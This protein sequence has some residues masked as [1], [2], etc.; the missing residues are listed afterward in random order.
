MRNV[1][2]SLLFIVMILSLQTIAQEQW[3]TYTGVANLCK[4]R[5]LE[6]LADNKG[7]IWIT[8]TGLSKYSG[9]QWTYFS[10]DFIWPY[11]ICVAADKN[12]NTWVGT[13]QG[14]TLLDSVG[15]W[16]SY[17]IKNCGLANNWIES[18]AIDSSRV[19]WFGT[20][21]GVSSFNGTTWTNYKASDG[22]AADTVNTIVVDKNNNKWF[23]TERGLSKFDG[24][25][26]KTYTTTDGLPANNINGLSIDASG[27]IW[28]ATW[29]GLVK[30]DGS[31]WRTYT[32]ADGLASDSIWSVTSRGSIVWAGFFRNEQKKGAAKFDGTSWTNYTIYDETND[33]DYS[34]PAVPA[35]AIDTFGDAWFASQGDAVFVQTATGTSK[36]YITTTHMYPD[37]KHCAATDADGFY[38]WFGSDGGLTAIAEG[39][40]AMKYTT[41]GAPTVITDIA[42]DITG[43]KWF[44]TMSGLYYLPNTWDAWV[45]YKTTDGLPT[46]ALTTVA[47]D[48]ESNKWIG[49]ENNGVIFFNGLSWKNY[50]TADGLASNSITDIVM[51]AKGR[52]WVCTQAS[53]ISCFDGTTWKNYTTTDGLISDAVICAALDIDGSLWFGTDKGLSKFDGTTWTNY[54][55]TDGLAGNQ[56]NVIKIDK[57]GV[58][59]IGCYKHSFSGLT[60]FDNKTWKSFTKNNSVDEMTNVF[61]ITIDGNGS[62]WIGTQDGSIILLKDGGAT[63]YSSPKRRI[64]GTLF[65]DAN[66][67]GIKDAGESVLGLDKQIVKVDSFYTTTN[68][69]GVFTILADAGK[70]VFTYVPYEYW[71]MTTNQI[72]MTTGKAEEDSLYIGLKATQA[73][74]DVKISLTGSRTRVLGSSNYWIDFKNVGSVSQSGSIVLTLDSLVKVS[75]TSSIP[76]TITANRLVWNFK[77]LSA[78]AKGQILVVATMPDFTHLGDTLKT[79]ASIR[80]T[81]Q[82]M[83]LSNNKSSL[84]Q[85]LVGSYDP[86][87]KEVAQGVGT[88]NYVL[89]NSLLEYTIHFQNTGTDTAYVVNIADTINANLD[90]GTLQI[91]GSSHTV[92][93]QIKDARTVIFSFNKINLPPVTKNETASNGYIKYS[94]KPITGL[95]DNTE[96]TNSASIYFDYN[97]PILT[98]TTSNMFVSIIPN[99]STA[100]NLITTDN[101]TSVYPNPTSDGINIRTGLPTEV[102]LYSFT[103]QTL[104]KTT[105]TS[106]TYIPLTGFIQGVYFLKLTNAKGVVEQKL[107]KK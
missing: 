57:A 34:R 85:V 37:L 10:T 74:A 65:N 30:Y 79:T 84:C 44:S 58:K 93:S 103:G 15:T 97:S 72:T 17:T 25:T 41:P 7:T 11:T 49:T 100:N 64:I 19:K 66:G 62:K 86:N 33:L 26:W 105:I 89:H 71:Q 1:K 39:G 32:T 96:V 63:A 107:I 5:H 35:L 88:K 87:D 59:W 36:T 78:Q 18:V 60:K 2:L 23:G 9:G 22:L 83:D 76:D 102:T 81:N 4:D 28:I 43:G 24:S 80:I 38:N 40:N 95:A 98:D 77:D 55:T 13:Y 68:V 67:N 101:E 99:G 91:I 104:L 90:L 47:V 42:V 16:T 82:D 3:R 12:D 46:N 8:G 29:H 69:D 61:S 70:H 27:N 52:E 48:Y 20:H 92:S 14:I 75:T 45:T 54:T 31:T 51:D 50:T 21:A 73:I 53:G 106:N 6:I 56:V 94:I